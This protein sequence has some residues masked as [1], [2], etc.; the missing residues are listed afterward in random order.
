MAKEFISERKAA[1]S[2]CMS[3]KISPSWP[4]SY[5]PVRRKT[6]CPPM[7]ASWVKP[8]RF[9]G[10]RYRTV[11]RWG[12]STGALRR[13]SG[14]NSAAAS[15]PVATGVGA[16]AMVTTSFA[17]SRLQP[18][19]RA[20]RPRLGLV[21]FS[22]LSS[23][24]G[25]EGLRGL[26]PV[27]VERHGLEAELP[28][29]GVDVHHLVDS[30]IVGEVDGLRDG[31]REEG[32]HR[33]HHLHVRHGLEVARAVL[34]AAVGA[35]EHRQV[36]V[37]QVRRALHRHAP[38]QCVAQEVNLGAG[39]TPVGEERSTPGP[40]RPLPAQGACRGRRRGRRQKTHPPP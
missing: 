13:T 12:E 15:L 30:G 11:W 10:S 28:S 34:A 23:A 35:V 32:L 26:A 19:P 8:R 5:S 18:Q 25:G 7:R 20:P 3:M 1:P 17:A 2:L 9:F 36:L 22:V 39:E 33:G 29:L 40:W 14:P 37:A 27:A 6:L 24:R 4:S 16:A 21:S 31:A 38:E